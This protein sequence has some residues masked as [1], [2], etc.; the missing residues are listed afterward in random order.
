MS[1]TTN[2]REIRGAYVRPGHHFRVIAGPYEWT[3][4]RIVGTFYDDASGEIECRTIN[5]GVCYVR[6]RD[7]VT[8][9]SHTSPYGGE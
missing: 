2:I 6:P 5:G 4:P 1:A 8:V 9:C 3:G 7:I